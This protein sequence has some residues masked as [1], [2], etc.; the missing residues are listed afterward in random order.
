LAATLASIFSGQAQPSLLK[1][2]PANNDGGVAVNAA[3]VFTFSEAMDPSQTSAQF[4]EAFDPLG[5]SLAASES[6]SADHRTLTCT[7]AP[8][9]PASQMIVWQV[10]GANPSGDALPDDTSGMFTTMSQAPA[11]SVSPTDK[12]AGVSPSA[13]VIFTFSVPMNT[14]ATEALFFGSSPPI[15]ALR[16]VTEWWS[17]DCTIL[18]CQAAPPFP[19]NHTILWSVAGSDKGGN[20]LP[21]TEG[22]FVTSSSTLPPTFEMLSR[23]ELV[24]QV[25]TTQ[26]QTVGGEFIALASASLTN[27][28]TVTTPAPVHTGTLAGAGWPDSLEFQD[29]LTSLSAFAASYPPGDYLL[30]VR[31]ASIPLSATLPLTDAPLPSA[32]HFLNWQ[33]VTNTVQG[34]SWSL[35]WDLAVGGVTADCLRLEVEQNGKVIYATP[36]PGALGAL[37]GASNLVIVPSGMVTNVGSATVRLTAFSC[38]SSNTSSISA[39]T[40]RAARHRTTSFQAQVVPGSVPMSAAQVY[41]IFQG[42]SFQQSGNLVTPLSPADWNCWVR[43]FQPGQLQDVAVLAPNGK[44]WQLNADTTGIDLAQNYPSS[45]AR[46]ADFPAGQYSM[47]ITRADGSTCQVHLNQA[48][49]DYPTTPALSADLAANPILP[50]TDL[51]LAW[52]PDPNA[53]LS[54]FV[55]VTILNSTTAAP[56]FATPWPGQS[57]ALSGFATSVTVPGNH[58]H[59]GDG[60]MLQVTRFRV[61]FSQNTAD[62]QGLALAG[63]T[64]TLIDYLHVTDTNTSPI[65]D[66]AEYRLLTGRVFAQNGGTTP[67]AAALGGFQFEASLWSMLAYT[68]T[69]VSLAPPGGAAVAVPAGGD[70]YLY[71]TN[72]PF[73]GESSLWSAVPTGI[74]QWSFDGPANGHQTPTNTL[75]KG[76]WPA[77]L[78]VA[79]WADLQSATFSN[80]VLVTW[81]LPAGTSANDQIELIVVDSNQKVVCRY[82]DYAGGAES[83]SATNT[84]I[85]IAGD[86]M[87]AG[88]HYEGRLRYVLVGHQDTQT[89]PGA[90]GLVGQF[91]ETRFTLRSASNPVLRITQFSLLSGNKLQL[92]LNA[93]INEPVTIQTSP[94][95]RQWQTL[96]STNMFFSGLLELTNP[97]AHVSFYRAYRGTP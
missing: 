85:S 29:S 12:T 83:I 63:S 96:L 77:P 76:T 50:G 65:S 88:Q 86:T 94:D 68:L 89:L 30:T 1:S 3:V 56:V 39:A 60:L 62:G 13:P 55:M 43:G 25:G 32:P 78:V 66:V 41:G 35:S 64:T 4:L 42:H 61:A 24:Q 71:Q 6:W 26:S 53:R 47:T 87:F 45:A 37:T 58:L 21:E 31:S 40:I 36:L 34:D 82:P 18:T 44:T 54:D 2:T 19:T 27:G 92:G 22:T 49:A 74:Y 46:A 97:P 16:G 51:R 59:P 57:G 5:G 93:Q 67:V 14:N 28:I 9:W 23:G 90:T 20:S 48:A 80:D 52:Q 91:A 73:D 69:N 75:A 11:F 17:P 10:T 38:T 7:P 33:N 15:L 81:T 72:R 8:A 95:L 79:N 84:S 70:G